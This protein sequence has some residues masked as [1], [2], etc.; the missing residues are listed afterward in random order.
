MRVAKRT[1]TDDPVV[2]RM[3]DQL[4]LQGK[5]EKDLVRSIGMSN[6]AFSTWKYENVKTYHKH[7]TDIAAFLGV[8][9]QY[10]LDGTDEYVNKDTMT[11]TEIKLIK[12][13][14]S[15]GNEQQK[16]FIKNGEFLAMSTKY[17]RMDAIVSGGK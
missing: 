6:T 15:M 11:G 4:K 17:E 12:L 8:T 7:I 2:L 13:F 1:L 10:L 5:T 3:M 16:C 14:R 9:E